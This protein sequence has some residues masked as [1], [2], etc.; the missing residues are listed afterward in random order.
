MAVCGIQV[1]VVPHMGGFWVWGVRFGLVLAGT[2][3]KDQNCAA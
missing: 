2:S 1:K 3:N